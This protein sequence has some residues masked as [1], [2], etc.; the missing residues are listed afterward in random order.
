MNKTSLCIGLL[1]LSGLA[2]ADEVGR[3]ISR[4]PIQQQVPVTHQVCGVQQVVTPAPRSGAGAA[5]GAI[6]G[7]AI[8]N[9]LGGGGGR[10]VATMVGLMGGAVL[11]DQL[12]GNGASQVSNVQQCSNQTAY[13][14]RTVAWNVVYEYAGQQ[15]TVQMPNDPGPTVRLQV[16]PVGSTTTAAA[17]PVY[18]Q[19]PTYVQQTYAQPVYAQ[20][21]Y[22]AAP[23]PGYYASP[24]YAPVGVSLNLGY[25]Y[26]YGGHRGH[27][28]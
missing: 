28:R 14:N 23:Y 24:Y 7:G 10:A 27:W 4:T 1:A 15:Y 18:T 22:V 11:G 12:E 2:N 6:A 9:T 3:V 20:P 17:P 25:N 8:G 13:E 26:G 19:Q 5:L 21:V 16:T